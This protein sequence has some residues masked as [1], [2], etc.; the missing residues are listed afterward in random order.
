MANLWPWVMVAGAGALH[1]LNPSAGW[2]LA[3][4]CGVRS[5]DGRDALRA[6]MPIAA[7]HAASIGM[8]AAVV[9][10][11]LSMD[12]RPLLVL[13]GAMLLVVV[14]LRVSRR[15]ARLWRAPAGRVGLALWSFMVSTVHGTG[16][17]LVPALIP[18]CLGDSPAREI[19]ASGSLPMVF[20][21][22][23]LHMAAMLSVTGL[24]ALGAC[25]G[26]DALRGRSAARRSLCRSAGS[27]LHPK[28][29][30]ARL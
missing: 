26:I 12:G 10:L 21:A 8:L 11:G 28:G 13:S 19:A 17:M 9:A 29:R 24:V 20:A 3:T 14:L 6:L 1:G 18:L 16:M 25:R 30:P 5:R 15:S 7:G 27:L 23:G 22:V 2:M 4:A